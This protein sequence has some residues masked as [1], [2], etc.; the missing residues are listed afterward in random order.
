MV[1]VGSG[2]E[3]GRQKWQ[4]HSQRHWLGEA[5]LFT[6]G[7]AGSMKYV[8]SYAKGLR[9]SRYANEKSNIFC[10][11]SYSFPVCFSQESVKIHF[12]L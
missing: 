7:F 2:G 3:A 12:Y 4:S 8:L 9:I 5:D 1:E 6:K 11:S 10:L